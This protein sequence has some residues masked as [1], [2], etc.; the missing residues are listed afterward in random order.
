MKAGLSSVSSQKVFSNSGKISENIWSDNFGMKKDKSSVESLAYKSLS[1]I[2]DDDN[3]S[4]N[5]FLTVSWT[6]FAN[7]GFLVN[8]I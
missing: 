4:M 5:P 2:I 7:F 6:S 3:K 8:I 1:K